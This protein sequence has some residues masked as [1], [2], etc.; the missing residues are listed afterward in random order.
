[1]P[2]DIIVRVHDSTA[3]MRY[4]TLPTRLAG[5]E[6]LDEAACAA[7]ITRDAMIGVATVSGSISGLLLEEP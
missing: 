5:T 7:L 4:V 2:E 1:M 3:Y 6:D